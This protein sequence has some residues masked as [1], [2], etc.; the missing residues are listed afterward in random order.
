RAGRGQKRPQPRRRASDV[1]GEGEHPSG[2]TGRTRGLLVDL[3][4]TPHRSDHGQR[5]RDSHLL[6]GRSRPLRIG[7]ERGCGPPQSS[8]PSRTGGAHH[9]AS[10]PPRAGGGRPAAP[11]RSMTGVAA[12]QP[13]RTAGFPALLFGLD[14]VVRPTAEVHMRAWARM[15]EEFLASRGVSQPYTDADYYAY[16]DG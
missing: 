6:L 8:P 15:F 4:R 14:G 2:A 13:S 11:A 9:P 1:R 16:V 5:L 3:E 7:A 12:A 10:G